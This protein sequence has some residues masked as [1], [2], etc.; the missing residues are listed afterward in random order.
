MERNEKAVRRT[1]IEPIPVNY[2][3]FYK[4]LWTKWLYFGMVKRQHDK[5]SCIL[6]KTRIRI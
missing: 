4:P 1:E 5:I 6:Y 2:T 3:I